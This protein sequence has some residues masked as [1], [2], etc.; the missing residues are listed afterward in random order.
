ML[1]GQLHVNAFNNY[2]ESEGDVSVMYPL[3][4]IILCTILLQRR[5][6]IIIFYMYIAYFHYS[7]EP[8]CS[9]CL[10]TFIQT[11]V[12]ALSLLEKELFNQLIA[13]LLFHL[14]RFLIIN[15]FLIS[16]LVV[17]L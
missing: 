2:K 13:R 4:A 15:C 6:F 1:A 9:F 10:S 17:L 14:C 11:K 8:L 12:A 16:S 7:F 3:I 5:N